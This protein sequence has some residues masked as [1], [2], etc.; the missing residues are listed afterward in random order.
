MLKTVYCP[1]CGKS[2]QVDIEKTFCFCLECGTKISID[3]ENKTDSPSIVLEEKEHGNIG[4]KDEESDPLKNKLDEVLFYYELSEE[5]KEAERTEG[6]PTYYLKAQDILLD[7]SDKYDDDYRIWWELSKPIDFK[8]PDKDIYFRFSFND[9]YFNKAID[10]AE[11]KLKRELI[12]QRDEYDEIKEGMRKEQEKKKLEEE[13]IK[14]EQIKIEQNNNLIAGN[15]L[16]VENKVDRLSYLSKHSQV[17]WGNLSHKMYENIDNV[18]FTLQLADNEQ[19]ISIFKVFS[20]T[21]FLIGVRIISNNSKLLGIIKDN[22]NYKL[23]KEQTIPIEFNNEG[24]IKAQNKNANILI[25]IGILK[26]SKLKVFGENGVC[27][28]LSNVPV[29]RDEEYVR[30]LL[31]NSKPNTWNMLKAY[32]YEKQGVVVKFF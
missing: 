9:E 12:R 20:G 21:L 7:L 22:R 8:H 11:L 18:Y 13:Q 32:E 5:K 27:E 6:N 28:Y 16:N 31:N 4:D 29:G 26:G 23:S 24:I 2:I 30:Y 19:L 10:R 3:T 14:I 17:L 1:E 15:E 25:N